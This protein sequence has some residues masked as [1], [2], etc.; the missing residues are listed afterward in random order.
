MKFTGVGYM[1]GNMEVNKCITIKTV[2]F[3][4]SRFACHYVPLYA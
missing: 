2:F 4:Q 3:Q 1:C